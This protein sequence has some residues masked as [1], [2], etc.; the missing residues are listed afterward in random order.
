MTATVH[1]PS[2]KRVV[3]LI[4][5]VLIGAF[6][7][8]VLSPITRGALIILLSQRDSGTVFFVPAGRQ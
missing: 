3:V 2:N 1:K 7:L 5:S 6:L 4:S 8:L